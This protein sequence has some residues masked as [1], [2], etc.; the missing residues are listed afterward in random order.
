MLVLK[1]RA[2]EA[3]RI[4]GGILIQILGND[5]I[6]IEAPRN[7]NIAR[8]ELSPLDDVVMVQD[9][10]SDDATTDAVTT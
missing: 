9:T 7:V 6:G 1:R 2:G 8:A 10:E 3:V 5:R 4:G